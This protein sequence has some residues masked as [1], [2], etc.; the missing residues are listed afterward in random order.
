MRKL[1]FFGNRSYRACI[2]PWILNIKLVLH[3]IQDFQESCLG[4]VLLSRQDRYTQDQDKTRLVYKIQEILSK[5]NTLENIDELIFFT[6][7]VQKKNVSAKC[8]LSWILQ[9]KADDFQVKI[10]FLVPTWNFQVSRLKNNFHRP[11]NIWTWR[12]YYY[13]R[14][15][16]VSFD[17]Y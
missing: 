10:Q 16:F 4:L 5:L 13:M 7:I 6:D 14:E 1:G 3:K 15:S 2:L 17:I 12:N 11:L 8:P 9:S